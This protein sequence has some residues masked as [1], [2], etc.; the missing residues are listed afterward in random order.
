MVHRAEVHALQAGSLG[1]ILALHHSKVMSTVPLKLIFILSS[2]LKY[3]FTETTFMKELFIIT[4]SR[5]E[6]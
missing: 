3:F 5:L 4:L 6:K 2:F 1:L